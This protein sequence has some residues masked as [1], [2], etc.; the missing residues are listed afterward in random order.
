MV[1]QSLKE[2]GGVEVGSF[3]ALECITGNIEYTTPS[4]CQPHRVLSF[5]F[6]WRKQIHNYIEVQKDGRHSICV[7]M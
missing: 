3:N 7:C 1:S 4:A 6:T 5:S 2:N